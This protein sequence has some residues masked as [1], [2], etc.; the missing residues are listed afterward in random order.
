M[1]KWL[2]NKWNSHTLNVQLPSQQAISFLDIYPRKM[3]TCLREDLYLNVHGHFIHLSQNKTKKSHMS[4]H[5]WID[6]LRC[7]YRVEYY[8]I[9]KRTEMLIH[10]I[11][12]NVKNNEAG[13]WSYIKGKYTMWSHLYEPLKMTNLTYSDKKEIG[14]SLVGNAELNV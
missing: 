7:I 12:M 4:V 5:G 9:T 3:K 11:W 2:Q 14:G 8:S 1:P 10:I 13:K 6:T